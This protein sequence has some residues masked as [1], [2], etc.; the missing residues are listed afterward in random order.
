ML[1]L[2]AD[3]IQIML[4]EDFGEAGVFRQ[5]AVAGMHRV[6]AGDLAGR[7]QRGDVEVAVLRR[8]RPDADAL[9]GKPHMHGV[10]IGGGMHRNG[11][12]AELL[13][14]AQHAKR[15]F[16]AVGYEDL[17]EHAVLIGE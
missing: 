11:G 14:R 8:R 7:K 3:E 12:D 5:E 1:G 15:D 9:V 4:G 6:G 16:T 10:G 13:A 2:R 17:V